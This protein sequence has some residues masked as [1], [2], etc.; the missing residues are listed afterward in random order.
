VDFIGSKEGGKKGGGSILIEE[1]TAC[2]GLP[3]LV[4]KK[5][6]NGEF[7]TNEARGTRRIRMDNAIRSIIFRH[8]GLQLAELREK[9][10]RE[11][12]IAGVQ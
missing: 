10:R 6:G 4:K 5:V 2:S 11:R 1:G 8:S 7:R 12:D 3:S 9:K